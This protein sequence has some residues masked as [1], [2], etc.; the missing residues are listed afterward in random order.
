MEVKI[1]I[2][3]IDRITGLFSKSETKPKSRQE[4]T[5]TSL[6]LPAY[7]YKKMELERTRLAR[8]G[9]YRLMDEDYVE[10][11]SFLDIYGDYATKEKDEG[12]GAFE[13]RSED[14]KVK[15]IIDEMVNRTRLQDTSWDTARNIAK[16]GDDFDEVIIGDDKL[17]A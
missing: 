9:D 4:T 14:A 8:Y 12:G 13:I 11:C 5:E 2:P 15:T 10:I 7:Y 16:L 17:I 1:N 6:S 3:L